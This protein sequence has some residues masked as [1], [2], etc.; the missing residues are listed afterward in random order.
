M[1]GIGGEKAVIKG[2]EG[3]GSVVTVQ[4]QRRKGGCIFCNV[5]KALTKVRE[6]IWKK[7]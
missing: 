3:A 2:E 1:G 5:L 7:G 4:H 6:I